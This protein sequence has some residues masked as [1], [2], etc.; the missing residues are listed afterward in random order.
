M[1]V[2]CI[3]VFSTFLVNKDESIR[4]RPKDVKISI[5]DVYKNETYDTNRPNSVES[6][7][8]S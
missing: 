3:V 7:Y 6:R 2:Y 1:P 4:G 8:D 5:T